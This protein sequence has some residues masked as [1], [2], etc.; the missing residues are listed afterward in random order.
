VS[1]F[2]VEI[3]SGDTFEVVVTEGSSFEVVMSNLAGP[4]GPQ[5]P[6][7][8]QGPTGPAGPQGEQGIQG[9]TGATGATGP[10]GPKGDTGDTGP[11]GPEGPT[12]PQG[13]QGIQGEQGPQGIQGET[14]PT[15]PKGDTGDTGPQGPTGPKGDTGDTGPMGPTGPQGPQ[16]PTGATGPAGPGVAAGGTTDQLLAKNSNTDYDTKWVNAPNAANGIPTGGTTGQ[17]LAKNSA[18]DYDSVW[19]D[20]TVTLSQVT[21]VTASAAEVNI[22]DGATLTTT[23]LNYVDGVTSAIQTQLDGKASSVHTHSLTDVTDVTASASELNI[24]DG[25][26]LSTTELN[27][28]DGVT[29][30]IQTQLDGKASTSH[31]HTL[32]AITDVTATASEVNVL[33]GITATTTELNYTDG[34]TSGIQ[35]QL[36]GKAA[37]SHTH[38]QSDITNLTTDL[39]AKIDKSI[40]DA[41]GDLIVATANDTPARLAVGATNGHVLTVDSAEAT[42]MKWAA[43]SGGGGGISDHG[44]TSGQYYGIPQGNINNAV[45]TEDL[46]VYYRFYIPAS[47]TF[48]RIACRTGT[49]FSGTAEVRLG[50]YNHDSSTDKPSTVKLDAGT[51]SCTASGTTYEITINETLSEGWY[52]FAFNCQTAATVNNSFAIIASPQWTIPASLVRYGAN[53]QS[54]QRWQESGV[55]GAFATAGTVSSNTQ[56]F[57]VVLRKS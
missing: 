3:T 56:I 42:G 50:I 53:F 12:G 31:T 54:Q 33:D 15:G 30:S 17:I 28:V 27:Y 9:P 6:T 44:W 25:A 26:T 8:L 23:E 5:G 43:A 18:T 16:G 55:T 37:S 32:S 41:K 4:Q 1:E 36:D 22:L 7:G 14:G 48:D 11:T 29:S 10:Q 20:K 49:N 13:P 40:V 34:V 39:A 24:L 52:W 19:I 35:G 46:T 51:V 2:N 45:A 57:A 47:A 21:D 38:A